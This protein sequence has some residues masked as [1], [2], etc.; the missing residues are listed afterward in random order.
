M[1]KTKARTRTKMR[2]RSRTK[3]TG[4]LK[5]VR[6]TARNYG[7]KLKGIKIFYDGAKPSGLRPDG[8][9]NLGKNILEILTQKF[10][11]KLALRAEIRRLPCAGLHR[12]GRCTSHLPEPEHYEAVPELGRGHCDTTQGPQSDI[13]RRDRV[14]GSQRHDMR[15]Q[16]NKSTWHPVSQSKAMTRYTSTGSGTTLEAWTCGD[17]AGSGKDS[18]AFSG[19]RAI[20]ANV[21]P[22]RHL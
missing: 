20:L 19:S 1:A 6:V 22:S 18:N 4:S 11:Q 3:A 14:R 2:V 16:F 10:G 9:I 12:I 7:K 8:S 13:R 17:V 21:S 15:D 5:F